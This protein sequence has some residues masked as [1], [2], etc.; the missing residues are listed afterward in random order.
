VSRNR[1]ECDGALTDTLCY[2]GIFSYPMSFYQLSSYLICKKPIPPSVLKETL[3][4]MARSQKIEVKN[5]R[6][7]LKGRPTVNWKERGHTAKEM[8]EKNYFVFSLLAKIPWLALLAVTGTAAA[9]NTTQGDDVD[10]FIVSKHARLW[11]TRFFTVLILKACDKYRTEKNP[12]GKIC[13]NIFLDEQSMAW[14]KPKRNLY[15]AHEIVMMRPVIN[16][17]NAYFKFMDENRWAFE[18]FGNL[19][20]AEKVR[21]E[22]VQPKSSAVNLLEKLLMRTQVWYMAQKITTEEI[23]ENLIHFNKGDHTQFVLKKYEE[24]RGLQKGRRFKGV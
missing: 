1:W 13:P 24:I 19:P 14:D 2:R 17:N 15:I 8:L 12:Q 10:I 3:H 20:S 9:H 23:T 4:K 6:Y 11:L 21:Y 18:F 5:G 22:I 7:S 16:K